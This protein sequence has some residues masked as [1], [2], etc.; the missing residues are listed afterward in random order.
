MHWKIALLLVLFTVVTQLLVRQQTRGV[1]SPT[2][3][4]YGSRL[5]QV[6]ERLNNRVMYYAAILP[7]DE[8]Q[9]WVATMSLDASF[10]AARNHPINGII[11]LVIVTG[12]NLSE[13]RASNWTSRSHVTLRMGQLL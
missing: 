2:C 12:E 11:V 13:S 6:D 7:N 9:Y 10:V 3:F 8:D 4:N 1:E 5:K